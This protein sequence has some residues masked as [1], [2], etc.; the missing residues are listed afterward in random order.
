MYDPHCV[1]TENFA[2][3]GRPIRYNFRTPFMVQSCKMACPKSV[4]NFTRS[5]NEG[6]TLIWTWALIW[7]KYLLTQ[8]W[9]LQT[10]SACPSDMHLTDLP[11]RHYFLPVLDSKYTINVKISAVPSDK[12][13]NFSPVHLYFYLS[14]TGGQSIISI[15]AYRKLANISCST[16]TN[17]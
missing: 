14:R 1:R 16:V 8:G 17:T 9:K 13:L 12:C 2:I 7:T 15:P 3:A 6:P 10:N 11:V 4:Q 5:Y